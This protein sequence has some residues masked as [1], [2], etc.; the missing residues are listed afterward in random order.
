LKLEW[1]KGSDPFNSFRIQPGE[2]VHWRV[3]GD[4]PQSGTV[5]ADQHGLVTVPAVKITKSRSRILIE[6]R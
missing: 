3:T 6:K 1:V 5:R 2:Q 4:H